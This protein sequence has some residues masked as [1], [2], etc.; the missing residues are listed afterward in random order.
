MAGKTP[1]QAVPAHSKSRG[2]KDGVSSQ[3]D[4][5]A[6]GGESDGAPYPNPYTGKPEHD[7]TMSA[8][9]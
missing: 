1:T 3:A 6:T 2:A 4:E 9:V 5:G 8:A 7:A